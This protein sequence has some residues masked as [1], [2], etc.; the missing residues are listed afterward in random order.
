MWQAFWGSRKQKALMMAS[1]AYSLTVLPPAILR[2]TNAAAQAGTNL[3]FAALLEALPEL[4]RGTEAAALRAEAATKLE[5]LVDVP[6]QALEDAAR[7][8]AKAGPRHRLEHVEHCSMEPCMCMLH[9][10]A[11][12]ALPRLFRVVAFFPCHVVPGTAPNCA[13]GTAGGRAAGVRQAARR[14]AAR[15]SGCL[16]AWAAWDA[17]RCWRGR[18]AGQAVAVSY[19]LLC[20][21]SGECTYQPANARLL[22]RVKPL[23]TCQT[24]AQGRAACGCAG[25][26]RAGCALTMRPVCRGM[27]Q[28]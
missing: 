13:A 26:G 9:T 19:A 2:A 22:L 16:R 11:A 20:A 18:L 10:A 28:P 21:C 7:R 25:G 5:E 27:Q 8:A 17:G 23:T 4:A 3:A 15:S 1:I 14:G 12:S 24:S 6:R